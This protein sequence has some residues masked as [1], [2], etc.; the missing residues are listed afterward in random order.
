MET[1][2]YV[3]MILIFASG[4]IT[5][6]AIVLDIDVLIEM[7]YTAMFTFVISYFVI[8]KENPYKQGQVDALTGK[9][10]YE[11]KTNPDSTKTWEFIEKEDENVKN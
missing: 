9:I 1:L 10:K 11:L 5:I 7:G 4:V 2:G 6:I 8:Q 3:F